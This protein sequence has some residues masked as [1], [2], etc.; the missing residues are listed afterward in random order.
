MS[1]LFSKNGPAEMQV[2]PLQSVE[3]AVL[4]GDHPF[5]AAEASRA[6]EN[7]RGE[8]AANP[9][10]FDGRMVFFDRVRLAEGALRAEG[11]LMP[12]SSFLWWRR[13]A[14]PPGGVHIF[15]WA[16]PVSSDGAVIAIRMGPQT[17][18]AGLVY[19]AAG[20]LDAN[21]I[22]GDRCD[23]AGNLRREVLEETGLDLSEAEPASGWYGLHRDRRVTLY[24]YFRFERTAEELLAAIG[25]HMAVDHEKEIDAAVAIRSADPK[26]H[27]Y[28]PM[29]LPILRQVFEAVDGAERV[30]RNPERLLHLGGTRLIPRR[31]A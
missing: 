30:L 14:P 9:A 27:P 24:R 26:A 2:F 21:D 19:C 25:R 8:I 20:S 15:G 29:M 31:I 13:Q 5:H 23:L 6:A 18:N 1:G 10:L 3:L 4:P 22:V 16:I 28:S 12:F 7:W 11:H 17:A